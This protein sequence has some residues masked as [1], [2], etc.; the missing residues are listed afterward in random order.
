ML[1]ISKVFPLFSTRSHS[2]KLRAGRQLDSKHLFRVEGRGSATIHDVTVSSMATRPLSLT[3]EALSE[4]MSAKERTEK[5]VERCKKSVASLQSF[6][7]SIN[8]QH[9]NSTDLGTVMENYDSV[10]ETLDNKMSEL[11]ANLKAINEQINTERSKLSGPV[12]NET[13]RFQAS[14]S[15]FAEREGDVEI[16]LIYGIASDFYRA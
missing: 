13:R 4:L 2:G 11:E 7:T 3:S 1:F 10:G 6:L 15:V 8:V 5:A 12:L 9:V 14:I 16:A